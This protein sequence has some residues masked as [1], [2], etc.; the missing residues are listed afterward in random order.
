MENLPPTV[1]Y[2]PYIIL[3]IAALLIIVDRP[4]VLII[5]NSL[6]MEELY[7]LLVVEDPQEGTFD[8]K[9]EVNKFITIPSVARPI[10]FTPK[11]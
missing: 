5:F 3:A 7:R 9:Q 6:S 1:L 4:F 11:P 10:V 8:R 2:F